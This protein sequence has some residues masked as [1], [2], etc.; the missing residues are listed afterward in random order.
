MRRYEKDK[1]RLIFVFVALAIILNGIVP[2][3]F[4]P[5]K[6]EQGTV[7][8]VICT[9]YGET[10]QHVDVA[11]S[12]LAFLDVH[13]DRSS[14]HSDDQSNK[15]PCPFSPQVNQ[16]MIY[17]MTPFDTVLSYDAYRYSFEQVMFQSTKVKFWHAQGP[18]Q[19]L[20]QS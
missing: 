16:A 8:I 9:A 7:A 13:D 6:T 14:N 3:G 2:L 5:G 19:L 1:T 10:V 4:M 11:N 12:P 17:D 18:P 20:I 15:K